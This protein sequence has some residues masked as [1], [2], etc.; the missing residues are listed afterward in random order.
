MSPHS[1]FPASCVSFLGILF[2]HGFMLCLSVFPPGTAE[3]AVPD[4][5][6]DTRPGAERAGQEAAVKV[7]RINI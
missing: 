6:R 5:G 2:L 1:S 7:I 4:D 3:K